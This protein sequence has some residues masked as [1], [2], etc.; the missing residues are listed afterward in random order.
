MAVTGITSGLYETHGLG[1]L[2]VLQW[3]IDKGSQSSDAEQILKHCLSSDGG[4]K[5]S[6]MKSKLQV[7]GWKRKPVNGM[8]VYTNSPSGCVI[9]RGRVMLLPLQSIFYF[10]VGYRVARFSSR[11]QLSRNKVIVGEPAVGP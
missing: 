4:L 9:Q 2:L 6:L 10:V 5:S 8:P 11:M 7:I 3:Q 1:C